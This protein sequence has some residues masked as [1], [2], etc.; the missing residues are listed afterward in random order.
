MAARRSSDAWAPPPPATAHLAWLHRAPAHPDI[1]LGAKAATLRRLALAAQPVPPGFCLAARVHRA[2]E[3]AG[4]AFPRAAARELRA[5]VER[6]A[7]DGA[8]LA[9]RSSTLEEDGAVASFA[10]RYRTLVGVAPA[11]VEDAIRACWASCRARRVRDYRERLGWAAVEPAMPVL[12]QRLVA[13]EASAVGFTLDPVDGRTDRVVLNLV[14][15]LG[16]P[17]VSGAASADT[18]VLDKRSL[19]QLAA[20][21]GA[22]GPVM[23]VRGTAVVT[24]EGR[25]RGAVLDAP[26][27]ADLAAACLDVEAVLGLPVDV[28]AAY[29]SG[30]WWIVQ[31]RPVTAA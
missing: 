26:R 22:G 30:R 5:A 16:S 20:E 12:V 29:A 11:D 21:P 18:V 17:L 3:A 4:G 1:E 13:A 28:E 14:P 27:I 25:P 8:P 7:P 15:G 24:E 23:R 31:A 6:L 9:V 10:G 19:E 2:A